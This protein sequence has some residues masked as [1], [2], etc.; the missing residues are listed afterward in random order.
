LFCFCFFR[1]FAP[2]FLFKLCSFCLRERKS[3]SC[4]R[5]QGTLATLRHCC[6]FVYGEIRMARRDIL[7]THKAAL[8]VRAQIKDD[9]CYQISFG[10]WKR[11]EAPQKPNRRATH[12]RNGSEVE[13]SRLGGEPKTIQRRSSDAEQSKS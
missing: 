4:L 9:W 7:K 13:G 3:I 11:K 5:V 12:P 10:G 1:T 8:K 6:H 2:T